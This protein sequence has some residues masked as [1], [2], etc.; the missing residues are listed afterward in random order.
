MQ[1]YKAGQALVKDREFK[2]NAA[3]FQDVFEV[4]RRYKIMSP[5]RMRGTYGKLL[6]MLMD[7]ANPDIQDLLEFSCIKCAAVFWLPRAF[8]LC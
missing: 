5:E 2:D 1:N 8:C 4:G 3:F 7:A 6:Y